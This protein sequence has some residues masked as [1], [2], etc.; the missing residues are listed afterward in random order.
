MM[1]DVE[2]D[3]T[4]YAQLS[5]EL[6]RYATALAGPADA[7]DVVSE[8]VL[9]CFTSRHWASVTNKRAYLY[10]AVLNQAH[11]QARSSQRRLSRER[12][13]SH[14]VDADA[15]AQSVDARRALARL[16]HQQRAVV[17]LTYWED[18]TPG[19]IADLLGVAEG[20]VR[21]QLARSR[22]H[23]RRILDD[24]AN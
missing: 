20:T 14:R 4:L 15:P 17:F 24:R 11:S 23:L 8:A 19:Q 9:A 10:R 12:R 6:I 7:P 16:S 5:A 1:T 2:S 21:K 13:V 18:R 22:E 3:E